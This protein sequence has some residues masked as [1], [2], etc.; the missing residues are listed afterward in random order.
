MDFELTDEQLAIREMMRDWV[1]KECPPD[2]IQRLDDAGEF[3]H[4]LWAKMAEL[5]ILGGPIPVEYG[6]T[7][8]GLIEECI[9]IEELSRGMFALGTIF[10]LAAY[11]GARSIAYHGSDEQR[12][13]FL[14]QIARGEVR[15]AFGITEPGGGTDILTALKTTAVQEGDSFRING[16][17][18]YTSMADVSDYILLVVRTSPIETKKSYGLSVFIVPTDAPGVEIRKLEKLGGRCLSTCEVFLTDVVVP[19]T[20]MVGERD[21]AWRQLTKTLNHE[22]ITVAA[23]ALGNAQAAQDEAMRFAQDRVAFGR[24]IGGFQAIQ[25]KLVDSAVEIE[26]ARLLMYKAAVSFESGQ[27]AFVESTAAKMIAS[28]VGFRVASRGMD[29]EAGHGFTMESPMQ[30]Y[31]R[32]SRQLVLGPITNEMARNVIGTEMGLP[33][34]Y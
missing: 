33:R 3:P 21:N 25:H 10:Q 19:A 28:D 5:G 6:G 27:S 8:L 24:P 26:M 11:C 16:Q 17:K 18:L 1:R 13:E 32:D 22:R 23:N 4:E 12:R 34:S 14:P 7:A 20:S 2:Y 31:F 29:I 30:R 15:F 9:I